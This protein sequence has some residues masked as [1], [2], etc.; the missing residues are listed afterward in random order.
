[1]PSLVQSARL[2]QLCN[3]LRIAILPYLDFIGFSFYLCGFQGGM[4]KLC[5][6]VPNNSRTSK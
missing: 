2:N 4:D 3:K 1:M 5:L 6:S